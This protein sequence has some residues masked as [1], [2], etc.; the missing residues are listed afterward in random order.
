MPD[1]PVVLC[2]HGSHQCAEIFSQRV[3]TL[4]RKSAHFVQFEFMDGLLE[5]PLQAGEQVPMRTWWTHSESST[6]PQ[7]E[8]SNAVNAVLTRLSSTPT[9]IGLL[10]FSQGASL[11]GHVLRALPQQHSLTFA[12]L[13]GAP[14]H[15]TQRITA[16]IPTLHCGGELDSLVPWRDSEAFSRLFADAVFLKHDGGHSVPQGACYVGTL[17]AFMAKGACKRSSGPS[18]ADYEA[19]ETLADELAG[20]R[21]IYTGDL[22]C[23]AKS[24]TLSVPLDEKDAVLHLTLTFGITYPEVAPDVSYNETGN[25]RVSKPRRWHTKFR[26]H[27]A[28]LMQM[29]EGDAMAYPLLE[30]AKEY[31]LEHPTDDGS[32][33]DVV[34]APPSPSPEHV[35][36]NTALHT[37]ES[38]EERLD[39][40]R[41][42]TALVS[43]LTMSQADW[44][45]SYGK[46]GRW[47]YTIGLVG[48]PS[49]GKST[50]FNAATGDATAAKVAAHPFTTI[51]PN[52]GAAL[53]GIPCPCTAGTLPTGGTTTQHALFAKDSPPQCEA[54]LSHTATGLRLATLTIR[55]VAGLVP[56]AYQGRG[57][58]NKFL[59]DLNDAD[60]LIHVVDASGRT[61]AE[62]QAR[63]VDSVKTTVEEDVLQEVHWVR[64]EI[65]QWIYTNVLRKW[66]AIR[67]R[68]E[69]LPIMFTGY[70][71]TTSM[72]HMAARKAN[73]TQK[74]MEQ[75]GTWDHETLHRLVAAFIR[76]RFPVVVAMNK[77]DVPGADRNVAY[78]KAK[79]PAETIVQLSA[80]IET[81]L[82]K[83]RDEGKIRYA[84]G[85]CPEGELPQHVKQYLAGNSNMSGVSAALSTAIGVRPTV[86]VY[87]V[88]DPGTFASYG[89]GVLQHCMHL[90]PGSTPADLFRHL[91]HAHFVEGD[92]VRATVIDSAS[93][94]DTI[95]KKDQ[96]LP[97]DAVVR[98]MTNRKSK[99]QANH[100]SG[101]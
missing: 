8:V 15:N 38:E 75:P 60:V 36:P 74:Q 33:E 90:T 94:V 67:R 18:D 77:C 9:C 58:G 54:E 88:L 30:G 98:I 56:G 4:A 5:M 37:E 27:L 41:T 19:N 48:K 11:V 71:A 47:Q 53:C 95:W 20:L 65:H 21:D 32:E 96:P 31:V 12:V 84:A 44:A 24:A 45:E 61:N 50:L 55:D 2:L 73:I 42:A 101:E 6:A 40:A 13:C 35:D 78:V 82:L 57:K 23:T 7:A 43:G 76:I 87:P 29:Y 99:W 39:H 92:F 14:L 68:P 83:L 25:S 28:D 3:K 91:T 17:T 72:V 85:G 34:S 69:K 1:L 81:Q 70:H 52:T 80:D 100:R 86:R 93:C 49:A 97:Q 62:G 79:L 16:G 89:G 51:E 22:V 46:G 63:E 59:D 10:G 64:L 66:D 26:A